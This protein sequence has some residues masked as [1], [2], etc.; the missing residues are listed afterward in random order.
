MIEFFV[1]SI[2]ISLP[3]S[4][5]VLHV[6]LWHNSILC[7]VCCL[8]ISNLCSPFYFILFCH[9]FVD[10]FLGSFVLHHGY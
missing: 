6:L 2:L 3:H 10:F 4:C 9:S 1:G 5:Y 8:I 7:H